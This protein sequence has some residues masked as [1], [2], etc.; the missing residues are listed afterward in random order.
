MKNICLGMSLLFYVLF[1]SSCVTSQ[2]GKIQT[3]KKQEDGKA[4]YKMG[5]KYFEGKGVPQDY[6][7]AAEWYRKAAEQGNTDA[8]FVLGAMYYKG[9]G[10]PQDYTVAAKWYR[11]AAK[12]G[13]ADIQ[14][15][16]GALYNYGQGVPQD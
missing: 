14:F 16:L 13:D 11:E 2:Q 6:T 7:K 10:V 8:Q 5:E 1:C 3:S 15:I 9:Q 4:E 12:Q